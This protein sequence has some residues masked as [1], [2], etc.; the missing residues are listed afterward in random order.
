[1]SGV[2]RQAITAGRMAT[3]LSLALWL[4]ACSG[5]G[6]PPPAPSAGRLAP[7][8]PRAF[9]PPPP[10]E[11]GA[12][13]RRSVTRIAERPPPGSREAESPAAGT[14]SVASRPNSAEGDEPSS[15]MAAGGT[16]L[17]TFRNTYYNFPNERHYRGA[18]VSLFDARCRTIARV[19]IAFHDTL[20]VQ[21]SGSLASGVTVSF[22]RRN[23]S[24]ARTCPRT[25]QQICFDRL[26]PDRFP[27]GRGAAGTAIVPL[28][29]VAVDVSVIPLG[30]RLF[31]PEYVGMPSEVGGG[32]A[33]DG[34]FVAEDRGIHVLGQHVDV[35]TGDVAV[36]RLWDRRVPT[37]HGVHV[38]VGSPSCERPTNGA[39]PMSSTDRNGR[40]LRA[41]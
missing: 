17:G 19:P 30:T 8:D 31:I 20:C 40:S 7:D 28:H 38:F 22:A 29:S 39:R 5:A 6:A 2:E 13:Q 4:S 10:H 37:N 24:C 18:K 35:F 12:R 23:C 16:A 41:M 1:V 32:P 3:A 21:G 14:D 11:P 9:E 26:D 33:H 27:W 25:G 15:G 36:T 34:C